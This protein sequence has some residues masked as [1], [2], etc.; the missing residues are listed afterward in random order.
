MRKDHINDAG[1]HPGGQAA[2]RWA[3]A[4]LGQ[5]VCAQRLAS[6]VLSY[7]LVQGR[8]GVAC[9]RYCQQRLVLAS[10]AVSSKEVVVQESVPSSF[11]RSLGIQL[12]LLLDDT[13]FF[14]C[15]GGGSLERMTKLMMS[16]VYK[17][18]L[19]LTR[20]DVALMGGVV[21]T[22]FV[23]ALMGGV[24]LMRLV[25]LTS[26]FVLMRVSKSIFYAY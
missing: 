1:C 13:Y 12:G 5:G 17:R 24:V 4:Y 15:A 14:L 22:R 8:G 9:G 16:V 7:G 6:L 19:A 3:K 26:F 2:A 10:M 11:R 25:A 20:F 21:V 18:F 23:V